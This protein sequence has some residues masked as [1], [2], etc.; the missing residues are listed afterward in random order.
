MKDT[1]KECGSSWDRV[2]G[3]K[4]TS[5]G[6]VSSGDGVIGMKGIVRLTKGTDKGCG[7]SWDGGNKDEGHQQRV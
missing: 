1:V 6:C 4:G 5:K 7:S 2:I 3:I